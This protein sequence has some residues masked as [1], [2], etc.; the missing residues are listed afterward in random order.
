MTSISQI[1]PTYAT[2]GISDQP[3]ELKKPGQVRDCVN[4]FP[5]L[6]GGLSKRNGFRL[7]K[8]LT[9][10]CTGGTTGRGGTWFQFTRENPVSKTKENFIGK[11]TFAGKIQVWNVE[12]GEAI[13]VFT[14][15]KEIDP[16]SSKK[17]DVSNLDSCLVHD[18]I[19]HEVNN[20]L[21]FNTVNNFTFIANPERAVTMSKRKS[22]RPYESFV[23][24]TQL[25][26]NREYLLDIDL[27]DSDETSEYKKVN[28]L[29]IVSTDDFRGENKEPS[30]PARLNEVMTIDED[31]I[32]DGPKRGQEGLIIRIQSTGIQVPIKKGKKFEC[33]YRHEV[34]V[35]NGGRNW[36]T[37]DTFRVYQNGTPDP[38]EGGDKK[39]NYTIEVTD[40]TTIRS[41]SEIQITGV[42]TNADGDTIL[43]VKNILDEMKNQIIATNEFDSESVEVVGNGVY[44]RNTKPFTIATSEKD[45][46]NILSNEDEELDN[47]YVT[48]NNVSRL[49]IECKDGIIAK[50]SNAFSDDDDY[51]VQFQANYGNDGEST[52]A[53]GY[54]EEVAE[55]GGR[56]KFNSGTM[57]H[58]LVYSRLSDGQTAFVFGPCNWKERTCGTD[59]FNPSFN[60]FNVNNIS[61]YRNRLVFLSRAGEVFNF[62][63][64]T[65]LTVAPLDPIDIT[66]STDFS[67]V[68]QDCMV[69][70]NGLLV[71]SN[72]QQFLFTT[73]SDILN[74]STAKMTEVS[75][76]EYNS[77]STPFIIGTNPAFMSSSDNHSR[78]YEMGSIYREGTVDLVERSEIVSKSIPPNLDR[79]TQSKETGLVLAAAYLTKDVWAYRYLKESA[80]KD[81]QS[82]WFRWTLPENFVFHSII[83]NTYYVIVEDSALSCSLLKMTLDNTKGPWTD[84][85]TD[86]D[87]G[88]PYEMRV[89]FPTINVVK[90]EQTNYMADT[91]ASLVVHRVY[92]N[93]ADIGSYYFD[94]KRNGMDDYSVLYESTFIDGYLADASPVM[95]EVER[96]IPVYTRNTALEVSLRSSFPN[97]LVLYSSRWEGDYN[98]RYYKR[99]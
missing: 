16:N 13:N 65:A 31:Y 35:I 17:I 70:N 62:F 63:P 76:Y 7:V 71:F 59:E 72:Y 38:D 80:N 92:Y 69:I 29:S 77:E 46:M 41:S 15:E 64:S 87:T 75:R 99:V 74:P 60:N 44:V 96:P 84:M 25:A 51:W 40:T 28:T 47:P 86:I 27:I 81:L 39:P 83:D 18:Y 78:F 14:S 20:T 57:P 67:S 26:P 5:D 4:A 36:K 8:T 58:A 45:L 79:I 61:F 73:D 1:V 9:N 85:Y 68:L 42:V 90:K 66:A 22:K 23:E 32:I 94:I 37:G 53:S 55:P 33:Q 10:I 50:V 19:A 12:T 2:G 82:A 95:P 89:D 97:P 6:I 93:F 43:T 91:T 21:K 24:V 48:V 98:N 49:P 88:V 3:D 52:S 54:W 11:A 34:E 30:C 56:V